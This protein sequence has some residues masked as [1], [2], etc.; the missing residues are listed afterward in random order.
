MQAFPPSKGQIDWQ[1]VRD[2][3]DLASV[4]T[5]LLGPAQ[6]RHGRRLLWRCPFHDDAH[7]SFEV[8]LTRKTW[9]CWSCAVGGDA[10]ELVKRINRCDFPAAVKFLAG[11]SGASPP[12][13][14][15]SRHRRQ[16]VCQAAG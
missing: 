15:G 8:N 4:A 5:N 16:A 10:A 13:G 12:R 3:V 6:E 9:R 7:P 1:D 14:N 2:R 11:L